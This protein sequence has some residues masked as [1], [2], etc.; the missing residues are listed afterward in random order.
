VAVGVKGTNIISG[1]QQDGMFYIEVPENDSILVLRY[2][3]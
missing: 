1:S 3:I 2:S